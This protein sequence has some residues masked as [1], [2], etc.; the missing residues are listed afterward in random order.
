LNAVNLA[1]YAQ[2]CLDKAIAEIVSK[3]ITTNLLLQLI[4]NILNLLVGTL[5]DIEIFFSF[6]VWVV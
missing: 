5:L 4:M 3:A 1:N 2:A 6:I